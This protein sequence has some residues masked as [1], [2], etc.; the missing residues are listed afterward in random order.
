MVLE[1]YLSVVSSLCSLCGFNIFGVRSVFSMDACHL[2]PQSVLVVIHLI[3]RGC[4][5]AVAGAW[6]W[7]PLWLRCAPMTHVGVEVDVNHSWSLSGRRQ[8]PVTTPGVWAAA[9]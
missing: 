3:D 5:D 6:P 8:G 9:S 4:A 2:F 1:D 7:G